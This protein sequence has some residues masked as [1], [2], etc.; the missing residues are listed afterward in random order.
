MN[1]LIAAAA[2]C[3]AA[4]ALL[5]VWVGIIRGLYALTGVMQGWW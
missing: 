1:A 2:W 4:V 3:A 5:A